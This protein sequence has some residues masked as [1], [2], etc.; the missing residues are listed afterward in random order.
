LKK[1]LDENNNIL[2][3][4]KIALEGETS[5]EDVQDSDSILIVDTTLGTN[6]TSTKVEQR[7]EKML[8]FED[9]LECEENSLKRHDLLVKQFISSLHFG[10]HLS[11]AE[12]DEENKLV[13]D[14]VE[15]MFDD[16]DI[17]KTFKHMEDEQHAFFY[18]NN[19]EIFALPKIYWVVRGETSIS[20]KSHPYLRSTNFF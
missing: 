1:Q 4:I 12:C 10:L 6:F 17:N 15:D 2:A 18:F 14:E 5:K 7:K 9:D 3:K 8:L 20:F 11:E 19:M 13:L 16:F